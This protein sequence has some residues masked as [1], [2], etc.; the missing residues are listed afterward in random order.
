M[1]APATSTAETTTSTQAQASSP[2]PAPY[3]HPIDWFG[4]GQKDSSHLL[5]EKT[6]EMICYMWFSPA[7]ATSSPSSSPSAS[8]SASASSLQLAASPGFVQFMQKVLETTQVSEAV[9]VLALHYIYA[10]KERNRTAHGQ[11]GSE[12]R[13]SIAGLMLAN[14]FVDD[15]TYT[16]KTWSEVSGIELV[17]INRM[18]REFLKGLGFTLYVDK[19]RYESWLKLLKG[20]VHAKERAL[21]DWHH[22]HHRVHD[23]HHLRAHRASRAQASHSRPP[24]AYP[25][26]SQQRSPAQ[27]VFV[28]RARS[29]SPCRPLRPTVGTL[30]PLAVPTPEYA[31]AKR[32]ADAAFSPTAVSFPAAEERPAKGIRLEIPSAAPVPSSRE[33]SPL[34]P[35]QSFARLSLGNGSPLSGAA[36]EGAALAAPYRVDPSRQ[37]A[38][39][40]NLYYYSI[41]CSPN[42]QPADAVV[43]PED[44]D[45][46][47]RARLRH[48][49]PVAPA[50]A[51]APATYGSSL[52]CPQPPA[53]APY[54]QS[55]SS[56][57]AHSRGGP[58]LLAPVPQLAVQPT[59]AL[60]SA[61]DPVWRAPSYGSWMPA[62]NGQVY[63]AQSARTSPIA[64]AYAADWQRGRAH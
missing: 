36:N 58:R 24:R 7:P 23:R 3:S 9:I 16:N 2:T 13:V 39:P 19:A 46:W 63:V 49:Q 14:K 29:T 54:V 56:S 18:E 40:Q 41:A 62:A 47:R 60:P 35:L 17:D 20:L 31:G 25:S 45:N 57:P 22:V 38:I 52:A 44:R 61:H 33:V 37:L 1:G 34:E 5:A 53:Y 27:A 30:P 42:A 51:P 43:E 48:H 59:L 55:A 8:T 21:R 11:P 10:L 50:P 32:S 64:Y 28:P 12:F 6:C 26:P 4:N 15:N